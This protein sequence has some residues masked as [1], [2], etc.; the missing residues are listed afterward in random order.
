[1]GF[2][3]KR[4]KEICTRALL[5]HTFAFNRPPQVSNNSRV[6]NN[7]TSNLFS[8]DL[9]CQPQLASITLKTFACMHATPVS[10]D[11]AREPL[12]ARARTST[13]VYLRAPVSRKFSLYT[14][15]ITTTS[16]LQLLHIYKMWRH[17]LTVLILHSY[18]PTTRNILP[19][20]SC[21]L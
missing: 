5:L 8:L 9:A 18:L 7:L 21:N 15:M 19:A 14:H 2:A 3:K 20:W 13:Q 4:L 17:L 1:M 12:H 16:L 10:Y 6:S 11:V